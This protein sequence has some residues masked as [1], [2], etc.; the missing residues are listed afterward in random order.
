VR[1]GERT[2]YSFVYSGSGSPHITYTNPSSTLVYVNLVHSQACLDWMRNPGSSTEV[3]TTS[4]RNNKLLSSQ[5]SSKAPA[6]DIVDRDEYVCQ[7]VSPGRANVQ[8][9]RDALTIGKTFSSKD[10][11]KQVIKALMQREGYTVSPNSTTETRMTMVCNH[12]YSPASSKL[13]FNCRWEVIL[14]RCDGEQS[15]SSQWCA[16]SAPKRLRDSIL[17]PFDRKIN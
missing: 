9:S 8:A 11:A 2:S 13:G 16:S 12:R 15:A 4:P 14:T 6:S 3:E 5:S 1:Q 7:L 10:S 17:M